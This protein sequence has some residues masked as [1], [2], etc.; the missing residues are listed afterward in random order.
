M[1]GRVYFSSQLKKQSSWK[2]MQSELEAV[3]PMT[4]KIG[5]ILPWQLPRFVKSSIPSRE[6]SHPQWSS[7][8][9]SP[10]SNK[11]HAHRWAPELVSCLILE[12]VKLATKINCHKW[13]TK[14]DLYWSWLC[15][16]LDCIISIFLFKHMAS[17]LRIPAV[18]HI[19]SAWPLSCRK[20]NWAYSNS[21]KIRIQ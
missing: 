6:W 15:S 11:I 21:Q 7:L 4:S 3:G 20:Q 8:P 19:T 1:G 10:S 18:F 2:S 5:Q 16:N 14:V 12:P 9:V 13:T 17:T